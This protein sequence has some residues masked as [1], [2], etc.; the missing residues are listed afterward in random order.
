MGG[1]KITVKVDIEST[2][3]RSNIEVPTCLI[4]GTDENA[5]EIILC[6]HLF[7]EPPQK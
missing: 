1:E 5:E 3:E 6:A 2:T 4:K 7:E